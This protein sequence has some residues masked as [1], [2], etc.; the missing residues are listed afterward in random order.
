MEELAKVISVHDQHVVVQSLVKS[1][2]SSCQQVDNCGTGIVAKAIPQQKMTL[3]IAT[4]L[5][6]D[7][8]DEV[9]IS[10]PEEAML[11]VAWRVYLWPLLG[12]IIAAGGVQYLMSQGLFNSEL[13]VMLA[14]GIG[15]FVGY[16][17][18]K[19]QLESSDAHQALQ[20]KITQKVINTRQ[21]A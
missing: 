6:L 9:L 15:A 5:S 18:S 4:D 17:I 13:M 10:I 21:L 14:G 12:L 19:T 1:T 7:V 3:E 16:K 8:G 11:S 20:P 2:C